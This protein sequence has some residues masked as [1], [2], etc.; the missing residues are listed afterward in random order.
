MIAA[1]LQAHHLTFYSKSAH[2]ERFSFLRSLSTPYL[3][4]LL[5]CVISVFI[6]TM[7]FEITEFGKLAQ[8]AFGG[9]LFYVH[10]IDKLFC[11]DLF[12]VGHECH[13]QVHQQPACP[14]VSVCPRMDGHQ[15]VMSP[16]TQIID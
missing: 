5:P 7:C 2:D 11:L 14:A 4:F 1:C 6:A 8:I 3:Y 12:F 15:L 10:P 13:K 9:C 16:E